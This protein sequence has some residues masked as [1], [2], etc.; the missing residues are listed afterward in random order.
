MVLVSGNHI[1]EYGMTAGGQMFERHH[2]GSKGIVRTT[3][4][5]EQFLRWLI[6]SE[7]DAD[8]R[9]WLER[10]KIKRRKGGNK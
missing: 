9:E 7:I 5:P 2:V 4:N 6:Q 10:M 3:S 8:T 1:I